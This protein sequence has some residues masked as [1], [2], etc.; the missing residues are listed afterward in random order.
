M[1]KALNGTID[2]LGIRDFCGEDLY[3]VYHLID[4]RTNEIKYVGIT[5]N[6]K[7]RYLQHLTP[8]NLKIK[9]K[10]NSWIKSLLKINLKPSIT[11]KY[12]C[13]KEDAFDNEKAEIKRLRDIGVDLKN[14]T[15][16]GDCVS[17]KTSLKRRIPICG[18][19]INTQDIVFL[20]KI[21]DC[22]QFG[23]H[24]SAVGAR[25]KG[26][27]YITGEY[28]FIKGHDKNLLLKEYNEYLNKTNPRCKPILGIN[29]NKETISFKSLIEAENF[30]F[31]HSN[32][33]RSIKTGIKC[34]G[35]YWSYV[36][37]K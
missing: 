24:C 2:L 3:F 7:R 20:D 15:D 9:T 35:Y 21:K 12:F 23:I 13:N 37:E 18:I 30:G 31:Q 27:L 32:I 36:E 4:P 17:E 16:G 33:I 6:P 34:K 10:K 8:S 11:I 22:E 29:E 25:F 19:N 1:F 28:F 14:S 26:K 5:N